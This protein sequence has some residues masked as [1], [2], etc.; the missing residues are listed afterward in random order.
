MK[1]HVLNLILT[2]ILTALILAAGA[3]A[4]DS[5]A[6]VPDEW[7]ASLI[8]DTP[9][10]G[11]ALAIRLARRAVTTTQSDRTALFQGRAEYAGNAEDLIATSHVVAVYFQTVAAAN[12]YW[13]D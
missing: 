6:E 10:D 4:D 9:A 12:D 3:F 5:Q 11:F 7:F 1:S 13:R 8:T 2:L